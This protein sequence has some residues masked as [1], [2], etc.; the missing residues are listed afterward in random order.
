MR[1]AQADVLSLAVGALQPLMIAAAQAGGSVDN[2]VLDQLTTWDAN[3]RADR[4]EPLIFTAWM[5]EAVRG[6]YQDDLGAAFDR[7]FD[8]RAQALIRL[9][10][11]RATGRDW[12]DDRTTPLRESCGAVLA[13]ALNRAL[14]RP[15][16][17]LRRRSLE[18]ALGHCA[19]RSRRASAVRHRARALRPPSMSRCRA[20]A[21]T[22]R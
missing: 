7:Y 10:E 18:V 20:P 3:M 13:A 4:P 15:G 14:A 9:L 12:C 19:L 6:I 17:A 11:G 2:A 21:A 16:G 1:A 8:S 5:R 22:T